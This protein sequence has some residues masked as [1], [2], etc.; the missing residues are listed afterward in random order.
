M[1]DRAKGCTCPDRS[2]DRRDRAPTGRATSVRKLPAPAAPAPSLEPTVAPRAEAAVAPTP[3][4]LPAPARPIVQA[5]SPERYRV[6]FTIGE[7]A[8]KLRHVQELLRREIPDGDPGAIFDRALRL[9]EAGREGEARGHDQA[10]VYPSRDG[11][12]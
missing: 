7:D 1:L 11:W 10:S 9:L 3:V 8:R 6:Q 2:P 5:T 4:I 12:K